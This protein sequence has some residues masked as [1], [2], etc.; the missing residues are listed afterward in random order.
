[1][2]AR[3]GTT[4]RPAPAL[5]AV[6]AALGVQALLLAGV[7]VLSVL[8]WIGDDRVDPRGAVATALFALAFAALLVAA[9]RGLLRGRRWARGPVVTVQLLALLAVAA[10]MLVGGPRWLGA[11]VGVLALTVLVGLF[12]RPVVEHTTASDEDPPTL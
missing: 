2:T 5:V 4:P 12:T 11:V 6:L 3:P 10:P 8:A 9:G 1:M 7:A